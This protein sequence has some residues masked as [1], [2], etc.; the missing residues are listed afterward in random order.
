DHFGLINRAR[1]EVSP[2]R[3]T[4]ALVVALGVTITVFGDRIVASLS[5]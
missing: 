1:R 5:R 2:V 4:G 3:L